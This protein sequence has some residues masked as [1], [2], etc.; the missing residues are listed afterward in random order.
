MQEKQMKTYLETRPLVKTE[1]QPM[2]DIYFKN[3]IL[4]ENGFKQF[5]KVAYAIRLMS[6]GINKSAFRAMF[7]GDELALNFASGCV[8]ETKKKLTQQQKF[9]IIKE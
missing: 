5:Q 6:K 1:K 8:K 3:C 4:T 2:F 9:G 7:E